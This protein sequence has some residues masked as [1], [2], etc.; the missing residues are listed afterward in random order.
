MILVAFALDAENAAEE[1]TARE[2]VS[3][4]F[5]PS[6]LP[7]RSPA[8]I[9]KMLKLQGT[10]T[11]GPLIGSRVEKTAK[12]YT[13]WEGARKCADIEA[14]GHFEI[15]WEGVYVA[16]LP[17]DEV[18]AKADWL[19]AYVDK[20]SGT[21]DRA[22]VR[23]ITLGWL[24]DIGFEPTVIPSLY[25]GDYRLAD[26]LEEIIAALPEGTWCTWNATEYGDET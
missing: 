8:M 21:Y 6:Q 23:R 18:R 1:Y 17:D 16:Q 5:P 24:L 19:T 22:T 4:G 3:R 25:Q 20:L 7:T 26:K 9:A 11:E 10:F 12:G 15:I 13:L 14:N 2:L